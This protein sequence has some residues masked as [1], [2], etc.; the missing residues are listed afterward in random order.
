MSRP[1][2]P[3]L[4]VRY[5]GSQRTFAAGHDVVVGRDLRADVRIAHPLI[6]RAHVLLRF[7]HDRWV[8]IDNGSLN[9]LF[10][11]GRRLPAV[12]VNDGLAVNIGNPDGPLLRFEVGHAT[13][14]VGR[15]PQTTS[16]PSTDRTTVYPPARH[17][18]AR[19]REAGRRPR[20]SRDRSRPTPARRSRRSRLVP[21]VRHRRA[22]A[23]Q[24]IGAAA[25]GSR[26]RAHS[27]GADRDP[28]GPAGPVTAP[29]WRPACSRSCG[30]GSPLMCRKARSRSVAP[31]TTTSSSPTSWRPGTTPR[32]CRRPPG[33]EIRRQPQHQ[34]HVRQ[35]PARR[36][37]HLAQRRRRHDR[38]RRPR[39]RRR[40]AE[41][42]VRDRGGHPHRR[43]RG[44]RPDVD[45]RGQQDTAGQHLDRR[46]TGHP[47]RDHR[48]VGRRQV[49]VRP[50]GRR[51]HP[52]DQR[53]GDVR[54]PRHPRRYAS[55]RS[56]IG[57][58]PAGRRGA[59]PADRQPG[60][61][62]RRRAAA[63]AGHH[64]RGPRPGGGPGARRAGDDPA[65]RHP[66]GQAV[67]RPAQTRIGGPGTADR[68]VAADPRRAHV[69][70]GPRAGPPGDDHAAPAG[71]R[72]PR[73]PG[74]HPLPDLPRC[75]RPGAAA[76]A[77]RKDRVLRAARRDRAR[78]GH[79]ELGR[80]LQLRGGRTQR[81]TPT[82]PG[83]QRAAAAGTGGHAAKRSG[84]AC[85][86]QPG[87]PVLHDRAAPDPAD[88]LRPRL[89][90]LPGAAAV[91]HGRAVAVGARH[92]RVRCTRPDGRRRPTSRARSW[93]CSTSARSSWA[94]R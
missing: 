41:P 22:P 65:R 28:P 70:S 16:I 24:R 49:D 85:E 37:G 72:R 15:P 89:L 57:M 92:R 6:S 90:H 4:T 27:D 58:V 5:D 62:V 67:G 66:R 26:Q 17:R 31:P 18:P 75:L 44:A 30:R 94:P 56:R 54:G 60:A 80:H 29:T 82:V 7:D 9:G 48:A 50:P 47:D 53:D 84:R 78:D 13:G 10:V 43:S 34:R 91:H 42:A 33:T 11:N 59:R 86:D 2:A 32:W 39:L 74:G 46:A 83:A 40:R 68:P 3:A 35:R 36:R 1:V 63:A 19:H 77:R 21:D 52:S 64:Q 69:R 79:D 87:A 23:G 14:S 45:H 71:R 55:L 8:A 51:L 12:D 20:T 76:G 73:G 81:V 61:D 38:Q 88:R 25:D 93:C